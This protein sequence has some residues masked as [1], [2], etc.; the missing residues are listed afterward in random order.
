M[1]YS[2]PNFGK[3]CIY[4]TGKLCQERAGCTECQVYRDYDKK[5]TTLKDYWY[6]NP[7]GGQDVNAD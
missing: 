5:T 6:G 1:E 2:N 3:D 4:H 7:G